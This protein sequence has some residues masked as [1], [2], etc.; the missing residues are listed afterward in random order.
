LGLLLGR[1]GR[2]DDALAEF[3]KAGCTEADAR[4]NLAF[5]LSLERRWPEARGQYRQALAADASSAPA[6]K[7]LKEL[8]AAMAKAPLH[9]PAT[10]PAPEGPGVPVSYWEVSDRPG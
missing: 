5:A 2:D 1:T 10:P 4:V 3:R 7:G 6:R 8:E 9:E